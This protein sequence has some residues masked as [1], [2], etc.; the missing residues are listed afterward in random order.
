MFLKMTG[1]KGNSMNNLAGF[2]KNPLLPV[3]RMFDSLTRVD[4]PAQT[5]SPPNEFKLV[6]QETH[7]DTSEAVMQFLPDILGRALARCWIDRNF[8]THFMENPKKMLANYSVHLPQNVEIDIEIEGVTRPKV[9]V[10][11]ISK[12]GRKKRLMYL[13]LVMMAGK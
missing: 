12:L 2:M 1:S 4:T 11:E 10:Y 7:F 3:L 8:M 6:K 9:V 13:Q 5:A